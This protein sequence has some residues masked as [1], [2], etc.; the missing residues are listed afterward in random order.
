MRQRQSW[1]NEGGNAMTIKEAR[2]TARLTQAETARLLTIGKRTLEDWE[3]GRRKPKNGEQFYVDRILALGN[4]TSEGRQS[5]LD[6]NWD[7][8][9]ILFL[10]K[11]S[12]A[13]RLSK[14]GGYPEIFQKN[15]E[16]IPEDI[17]GK[18]TAA[19]IAALVD[20]IKKAYDDGKKA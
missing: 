15:W 10:Y 20:A 18:L 7:I 14:W 9:D 3:S 2:L 5:Y 12:E 11:R 1:M 13:E 4:L 17:L 6:G 19:E 8:E 16:R